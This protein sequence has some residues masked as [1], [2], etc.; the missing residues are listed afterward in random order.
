MQGCRPH[1]D[2]PLPTGAVDVLSWFSYAR[3]QVPGLYTRYVGRPQQVE[4]SG[5]D[6]PGFPLLSR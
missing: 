5:E 3:E 2:Q 1:A 4:L 6:Q